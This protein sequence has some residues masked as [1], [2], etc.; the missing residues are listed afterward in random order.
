MLID[1]GLAMECVRCLALGFVAQ[2]SR[3]WSQ[4]R[5]KTKQKTWPWVLLFAS[6]A[7]AQVAM[8]VSHPELIADAYSLM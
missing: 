2:V 4:Q 3:E 5:R 6:M 7:L 8:G 1:N